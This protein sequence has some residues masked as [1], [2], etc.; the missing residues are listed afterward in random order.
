MGYVV[1]NPAIKVAKARKTTAEAVVLAVNGGQS[2]TVSMRVAP[3][4]VPSGA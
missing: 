3:V 1:T 2:P 4:R